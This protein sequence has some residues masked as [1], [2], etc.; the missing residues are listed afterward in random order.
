MSANSETD[1]S[2]ESC[3]FHFPT[4][5]PC[6]TKVDALETSDVPIL[7]FSLRLRLD[8]KLHVL[9]LVCNPLQLSTPQWDIVLDLTNLTYQPTTKSSEQLGQQKRHVTFA[10]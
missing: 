1:T 2:K 6:S 9:L 7:F 8:P 3:V 4:N 10:M 5:P